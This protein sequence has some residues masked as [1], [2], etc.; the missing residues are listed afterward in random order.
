MRARAKPLPAELRASQILGAA[1][2]LAETGRWTTMTRQDI[3][4]EAGVSEGLVSWRLGSEQDIRQSVMRQAILEGNAA[5]VAQG[6]VVRD[7]IAA[8]APARL[9]R[10]AA[11]YVAAA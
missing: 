11:A 1:M 4:R 5:I 7:S 8:G 9:K 2:R 6:L 3:A 10:K